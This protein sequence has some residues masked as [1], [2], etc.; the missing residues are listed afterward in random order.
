[1]LERYPI[2]AQLEGKVTFHIE[3]VETGEVREF[4][5]NNAV[6]PSAARMICGALAQ[7]PGTFLNTIEV[8]YTGNVLA[9]VSATITADIP[10]GGPYSITATALIPVSAFNGPID[11]VSLRVFGYDIFSEANLSPVV[12]KAAN[13]QLLLTWKIIIS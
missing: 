3:N 5:R 11:Y 2:T 1:M 13:E 4:T 8:E 10:P 12:V 9:T 7:V 6:L